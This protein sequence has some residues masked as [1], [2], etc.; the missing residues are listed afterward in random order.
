MFLGKEW[1]KDPLQLN[2]CPMPSVLLLHNLKTSENQR[3][4]DF[5]M[6]LELEHWAKTG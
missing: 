2:R 5:F 4:F 1:V 3:F 6:G